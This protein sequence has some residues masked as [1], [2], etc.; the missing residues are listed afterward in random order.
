MSRQAN[1]E[2]H[3]VL[4]AHYTTFTMALMTNFRQ[5][6]GSQP[7]SLPACDSPCLLLGGDEL[8]RCAASSADCAAALPPSASFDVDDEDEPL[9]L[10][11]ELPP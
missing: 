9:L 1:E 11:D 8:P 10:D 3:D 7:E 4:K 6:V 5:Q 2:I